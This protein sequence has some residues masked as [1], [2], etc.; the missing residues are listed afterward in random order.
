VRAAFWFPGKIE[1]VEKI[2]SPK[3]AWHGWRESFRMSRNAF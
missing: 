1:K 2:L 3:R